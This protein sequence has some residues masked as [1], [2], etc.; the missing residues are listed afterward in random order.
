MYRNLIIK[1]VTFLAGLYFFLE[2]IVPDSVLALYNLNS[3]HEKISDAFILVG[4]MSIGLGI[5]NLVTVYGVKI[6]YKR[7]GYFYSYALLLGLLVMLLVSIVDWRADINSRKI[8]DRL[9]MLSKFSTVIVSDVVS[10]KEGV[11]AFDKRVEFLKND[12]K[13]TLI[14]IE[15]ESLLFEKTKEIKKSDKIKLKNYTVA[16]NKII[17]KIRANI[18][19]IETND[20]LRELAKDLQALSALH[21]NKVL[22]HINY[23][24][25]KRAWTLLFNGLFVSLGS[26]MF[27]ILGVYIASAAYRA[28]RISSFESAFMLFAAL[29]VMLGQI[30][31]GEYITEDMPA[32]RS[33]LLEVPNTAAFRAIRIGSAIAGLVLAYRMWFSIE[34]NYGE[35]S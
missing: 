25:T 16:V 27:S 24:N 14:E 17:K 29:L 11:L 10:E 9:N 32:I 3:L 26:A 4:A 31:F 8:V 7:K 6:V 1:T 5:I 28:F 33:W 22:I 35:K 2:W 18:I 15:E 20:E 23:T 13:S 12:L 34:S 21:Y 19:S 30:P